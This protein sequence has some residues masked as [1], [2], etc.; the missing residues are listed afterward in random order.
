MGA[1]NLPSTTSAIYKTLHATATEFVRANDQD[2]SSPTR[3]NQER[4]KAIRSKIGFQH[5]WGHNYFASTT[6][7]TSGV[8][9]V[10]GFISHMGTMVPRLASWHTEITDIVID[11][12]RM[13]AV[14]RGSYYMLAKGTE[15]PVENDLVWF[16]TMK[17]DGKTVRKSVEFIDAAAGRR[18]RNI[19]RDV[20]SEG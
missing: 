2:L 18:L 4:I 3:I 8:L 19:M 13:M 11:E 6:P 10:E 9:D 16:L 5:S 15:E 12:A 14:L 7:T 17:E 1:N 20:S